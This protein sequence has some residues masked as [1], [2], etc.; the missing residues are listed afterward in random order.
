MMR[1][2]TVAGT[3]YYSR[4]GKSFKGQVKD[5]FLLAD[6]RAVLSGNYI[7]FA[8]LSAVAAPKHLFSFVSSTVHVKPTHYDETHKLF[9]VEL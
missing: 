8:I 5:R 6:C 7:K 3:T 1:V 2:R 4:T 9:V